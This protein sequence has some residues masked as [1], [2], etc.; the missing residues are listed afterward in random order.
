ME[1]TAKLNYTEQEKRNIELVK[2]YMRISYSPKEASGDA[3]KRLCVDG[4]GTFIAPT[5]FPTTHTLTQYADDHAVIMKSLN[6]LHIISYDVIFAKENLVCL[7]YSAEG[8]HNGE[9]HK[10][11]NQIIQPTHK[12]ARWTAAGIF[13]IENGKIK[14]FIKEWD[15]VS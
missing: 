8:S 7:R 3:V 12:R 11:G 9:P 6:D 1:S 15:K 5:T 4:G 14:K 13:E 2:E 10:D